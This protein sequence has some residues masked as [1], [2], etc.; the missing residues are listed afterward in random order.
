MRHLTQR[1][2]QLHW[3]APGVGVMDAESDESS[4]P[5]DMLEEEANQEEEE[6]QDPVQRLPS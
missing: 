1:G 3:G 2:H 5:S 4:S 6:N